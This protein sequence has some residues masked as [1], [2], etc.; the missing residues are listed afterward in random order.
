MDG[1]RSRVALVVLLLTLLAGQLVWFGAH[2]PPNPNLSANALHANYASYVGQRVVVAAPVV[3]TD[4]VVIALGDRA[5][6]RLT[7]R[8]V[9]ERVSVGDRLKIYG[10]V[11]PGHEMRAIDTVVV[12]RWG[13]WY[14]Y[15]VSFLAGMW[16]LLR[17]VRYWRFDA[18]S[19]ALERRE[20]PYDLRTSIL[21]GD[22]DA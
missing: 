17:L 13:L 6:A 4:P 18:G 8:G 3:A 10:V 20:R 21:G 14:T 9:E 15:T 11:R 16:V 2:P 7:V 5:D 22:D 1:L 12:S 19:L